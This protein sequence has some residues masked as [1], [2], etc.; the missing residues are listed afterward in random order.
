MIGLALI[1]VAVFLGSIV[2]VP[3]AMGSAKAPRAVHGVNASTRGTSG[4][5]A[6]QLADARIA[7]AKYALNLKQAKKDGYFILTRAIPDMGYHF[8]NPNI[9]GFDVTKPPILVYEKH[10]ENW[11]L[12]AFEWVFTKTPATPPLDGATYGSFGAACHYHDGT[13]V[14]EPAQS[15][16]PATSP[17]TGSAFRFWHPDLVTMHVWVWYPN[18]DGLYAGMNPLVHP[19]NPA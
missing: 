17:D 19:F 7:T 14:F 10:G 4:D 15:D 3:A 12:G 2:V 16:C 9:T 5:L 11:Q 1:V 8:L 6:A 18:P 13:F